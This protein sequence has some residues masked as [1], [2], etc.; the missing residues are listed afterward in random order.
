MNAVI[1]QLSDFDWFCDVSR[2]EAEQALRQMKPVVAGRFLVRPCASRR[3][4]AIS[5][6]PLARPD[7]LVHTK[8]LLSGGE[9]CVEHTDKKFA[10]IS[11]LVQSLKLEPMNKYIVFIFS[12][13]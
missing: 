6:I 13:H 12:F 9:W 2:N 8:V 10:T 3:A 7:E 5:Y 11:A 4:L 1:G